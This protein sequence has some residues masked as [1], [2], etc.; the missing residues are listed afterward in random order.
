M[1]SRLPP[2]RR[3]QS[4]APSLQRVFL[5]AFP[6]TT[7]PS[8]SLPAPCHFIR[9]SLYPRPFPDLAARQGLSCSPLFFPNVPPPTSPETSTTPPCPDS[10]LLPPPHYHRP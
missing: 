6:G 2:G 10:C 9:P 3:D 5:R 8:D 1:P 7:D 4:R